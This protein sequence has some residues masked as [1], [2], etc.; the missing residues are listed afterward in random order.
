MKGNPRSSSPP[1]STPPE[2]GVRPGLVWFI[3]LA[4]V[5]VLVLA[6]FFRPGSAPAPT[7]GGA[8][9]VAGSSGGGG[10][11]GDAWQRPAGGVRW[12]RAA[13]DGARPPETIVADKAAGFARAR[14]QVANTLARKAGVDA[15]P[16]VEQF[17]A[18]AESGNW[19]DIKGLYNTLSSMRYGTNAPKDLEVMWPA[20]AETFGAVGVARSWPAEELLAY[21]ESVLS[22]LRP[23]TVYLAGTDAGR[24]IPTLM[25]DGAGPNRAMVVT[26]ESLL[27]P[28]FVEYLGMVHG[29]RIEVPTQE[30][31]Q[32]AAQTRASDPRR[33][34]GSLPTIL[35]ALMDKNPGVNFA[36]EATIPSEALPGQAVPLGPVLELRSGDAGSEGL[37]AAQ[38]AESA[39]Y[40]Q[41]TAQRLQGVASLDPDSETRRSYAQLATAQADLFVRN[42]LVTE[43]EQA[44]RAAYDIAPGAID[45]V[46]RL[47]QF[48]AHQG[49]TAEAIQTLDTFAQNQPGMAA[50]VAELRKG[51]AN[52]SGQPAGD[53]R[54]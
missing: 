18:A 5:G 4:T 11:A 48:L 22:A 36:V 16:E 45:P 17:F 25:E 33:S 2:S 24:F 15:S 6:L 34:G 29:E 8:P 53:R 1:P 19:G 44:F 35:Q 52:P 50:S 20:I 39:Q 46:S 54:P 26:A 10:A 27:D 3:A 7:G 30:D 43:A 32:K 28:S 42:N 41:A 9:A 12:A 21:G 51:L 38:A 37:S 40:W 23:G 49:R 13:R 14:R 47:A 31:L